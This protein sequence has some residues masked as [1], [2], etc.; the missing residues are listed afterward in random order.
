MVKKEKSKLFEC[1][2]CKKSFP[3]QDMYPHWQDR[4]DDAH[5]KLE[6]EIETAANDAYFEA[7]QDFVL[8]FCAEVKDAKR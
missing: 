5:R 1:P 3:L 2:A 8:E 7:E 4:E 6:H